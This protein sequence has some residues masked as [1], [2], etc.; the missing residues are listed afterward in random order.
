[1]VRRSM[2]DLGEALQRAVDRAESDPR[3]GGFTLVELVVALAVSGIVVLAAHAGLAVLTDGWARS[4]QA[5]VPVL[6]GASARAT[7]ESWIRRAT[8]L[9][10]SGPFRGTDAYRAG[11]SA[12]EVSFDT[13]DC[14]ALRPGPC[15]VRLWVEGPQAGGRRGLLAE[16]TPVGG[17]SAMPAETLTVAPGAT[18]LELRYLV[19]QP[20]GTTWRD[21]WESK[22]LLPRAVALRVSRIGAIQL[23]PGATATSAL[24]PL[25]QLPLVVPIE[26]VVW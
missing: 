22:D 9:P 17:N 3:R 14:G 21:S 1:M 13:G 11:Q 10:G 18:G 6:S 16:L 26:T 2:S 12:D 8:F 19:P 4:H 20:G 23:G 5:A 15:R 7:L 24:A 25:L